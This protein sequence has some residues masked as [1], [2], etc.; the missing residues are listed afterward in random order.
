MN[1]QVPLEQK[2]KSLSEY[3]DYY[4]ICNRA[5]D[6]SPKTVV[7]YSANLRTFYSYLKSHH[8]PDTLEKIDI[9][10]LRQ[11]VLYLLKKNKEFVR[12]PRSCPR[13]VERRYGLLKQPPC[14]T[15]SL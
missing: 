11:Y 5:E 7:W 15:L 8:L 3:I 9:K 14:Q 2:A 1:T 12:G 10:I 6:K 13:D 4:E